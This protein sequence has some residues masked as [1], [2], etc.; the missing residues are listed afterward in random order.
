M[1]HNLVQR[2]WIMSYTSPGL[3]IQPCLIFKCHLYCLN[4]LIIN[5]IGGSPSP[6]TLVASPVSDVG[7]HLVLTTPEASPVVPPGA[8]TRVS[9]PLPQSLSHANLASRTG[10]ATISSFSDAGGMVGLFSSRAS[11]SSTPPAPSPHWPA[12]LRLYRPCPY[13]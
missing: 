6:T 1:E 4:Y 7:P 10:P 12:A 9:S 13:L 11:A 8:I 3:R 5:F 2:I